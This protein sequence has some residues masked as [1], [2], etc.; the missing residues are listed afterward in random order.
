MRT[1]KQVRGWCD[2]D[3]LYRSQ[4]ERVESGHFV[5]VGAWLGQSACMM[6]SLIRESGKPIWF[7]VVEHG[8]G[9]PGVQCEL[10]QL[11]ASGRSIIGQLRRN[12]VACG[13]EA[14][15]H[16]REMDSVA[17]AHTYHEQTLDF[18]FIDANHTEEAV[19][20][21]LIAWLPRVR[22]GGVL[23]GHDWNHMGVQRAVLQFFQPHIEGSCWV[24]VVPGR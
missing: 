2:F 16:V 19:R 5:E 24:Y 22:S 18:V 21:D 17:A 13:V 20:R 23:A 11:E 4:V 15:V 12:I 14:F 1:W 7:D 10:E 8:L 3:R 9:D 6:G